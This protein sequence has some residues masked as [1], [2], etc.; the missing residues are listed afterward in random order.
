MR[1]HHVN[2]P[3]CS[4]APP[5]SAHTGTRTGDHDL[6][7]LEKVSSLALPC[8]S[9]VR[10]RG[11]IVQL[12]VL[13]LVHKRM[14]STS[15]SSSPVPVKRASPC[16]VGVVAD[17]GCVCVH[18]L[19]CV[20]IPERA[21][22]SPRAREGGRASQTAREEGERAAYL[23][24]VLHVEEVCVTLFGSHRR[25]ALGSA[26]RVRVQSLCAGG[27][28]AQEPCVSWSIRVSVHVRV[29]RASAWSCMCMSGNKRRGCR[30]AARARGGGGGFY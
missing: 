29:C 5:A 9:R 16:W 25:H 20:C 4:H 12:N 8:A 19:C 11:R 18:P 1:V 23:D 30:G 17:G 3:T 14:S 22:Q 6:H 2:G 24:Q 27:M 7:V 26:A 28:C 10:A 21:R 15:S 13:V